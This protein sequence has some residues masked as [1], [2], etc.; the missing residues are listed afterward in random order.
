VEACS[1]RGGTIQDAVIQKIDVPEASYHSVL[2][3]NQCSQ[4][5]CARVCPTGALSQSVAGT[6]V[7]DSKLCVGCGIC[8]LLCPYGGIHTQPKEHKSNKCD[9]CGGDPECAH[10]CPHGILDFKKASAITDQLSDD[11]LTNGLPYCAGCGMELV[12]RYALR[13]LGNNV[14]VFGAPGC[15]VL[16]GKSKVPYFGT[17]MT[18]VASSATGV[19]RYFSRIK[20]DTL[21]VAIIGDG[22]T[23]DIGFGGISAAAERG[24]KILYI[25]YD[26]EAY[27]N[28][29][30][31]RSGTTPFGSWTNTT[32]V[33]S[34]GRGKQGG[35]KNIPL[36]MVFHNIEYVATA[37]LAY[38]EDFMQKLLKA[39]QAAKKGMAYLHVLSPCPTGWKCSSEDTVEVTRAAVETNYF[40]LWEAEQGKIKFTHVTPER[41]PIQEFTRYMG[42]FSHLSGDEIDALQKHVD[43]SFDQIKRISL[44]M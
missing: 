35:P 21:C 15:N 18:N 20:K 40:P 2:I 29:G 42:R 16:G 30:V 44:C 33:G 8:N 39:S 12:D 17:L 11:V 13:V 22:A 10:A 25:C 31:Q 34:R 23:A 27:M 41:A 5:D 26:N 9:Y 24:E 37:T 6:V 14:V 7:L 19:S 32:Q 43:S 38:P 36:L 1:R 3:C 28:T 4:P